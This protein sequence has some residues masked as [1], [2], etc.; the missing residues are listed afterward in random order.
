MVSLGSNVTTMKLVKVGMVDSQ[1]NLLLC[2]VAQNSSVKNILVSSNQLTEESLRMVLNFVRKIK[3]LERVYM[4][5]NRIG[6]FGGRKLLNQIK[7]CG[8]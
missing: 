7:E 3:Q 2:F 1:F 4:N 6:G 8:V 5:N